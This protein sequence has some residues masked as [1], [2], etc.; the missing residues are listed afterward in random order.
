MS[1]RER[2][3]LPQYPKLDWAAL[4]V[5]RA[6]PMP[7]TNDEIDEVLIAALNLT[8]EQRAV[9][10]ANG[11]GSEVSYRAAWCRTHLKNVGAIE[12]AGRSLWRLTDEGATMSEETLD[13]RYRDYLRSVRGRPKG[14]QSA[15]NAQSVLVDEDGADVF[16]EISWK[17]ELLLRLKSMSPGG[18]E[19]LAKRLLKACDFQEVKVTGS[20]GDGGIDGTALYRFSLISSPVYFQCKRYQGSVGPKVVREFRGALPGP[21]D[22]GLIITT[23]VFTRGARTE[24]TRPG[25]LPLDL[26]DGD[27]LCDLLKERK[28]GVEVRE[29]TVEDVTIDEQYFDRFER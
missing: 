15:A 27:G 19:E 12:S 21:N 1:R 4:E 8:E 20:S 13:R 23:G 17:D 10:A 29:R 26:I 3:G 9:P 16:G 18:F 6:L 22:R 25:Y 2:A 24:A 28:L 7:A 14:G 5:I 11:R